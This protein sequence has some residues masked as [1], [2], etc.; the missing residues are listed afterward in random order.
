MR[1]IDGM[2]TENNDIRPTGNTNTNNT[3][4]GRR[5]GEKLKKRDIEKEAKEVTGEYIKRMTDLG[6]H[7]VCE[8]GTIYGDSGFTIMGHMD[9]GVDKNDPL[10]VDDILYSDHSPRNKNYLKGG[11]KRRLKVRMRK[12]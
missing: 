11:I 1:Y 4:P 5:G 6:Y 9:S 12:N 3:A 2:Q 7:V 10:Y 8:S